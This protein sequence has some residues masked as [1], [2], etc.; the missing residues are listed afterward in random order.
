MGRSVTVQQ[1]H[2]VGLPDG[3]QYDAADGD[4]TVLLSD[5]E[6][7]NFNADVI[8]AGIVTDNGAAS[9]PGDGGGVT[10]AARLD[11]GVRW[12]RSGP[13][14]SAN[15]GIDYVADIGTADPYDEI[16]VDD[17]EPWVTLWTYPAPMVTAAG[18]YFI[19]FDV[20]GPSLA[21]TDDNLACQ[22]SM[23]FA[24]GDGSDLF[25]NDSALLDVMASD[26]VVWPSEDTPHAA[27]SV[28]IPLPANA[29]ID[30][31]G[32]F[33]GVINGAP[34]AIDGNFSMSLLIFRL[35]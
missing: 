8:T 25:R 29:H 26:R 34:Y 2:Y 35:A 9:A 15:Q 18:L 23:F 22:A 20:L 14:D 19:R 27:V 11:Q 16:V 13:F 1:P 31:G 4:I 30:V 21:I 12:D 6:W 32:Q 3:K 5:E 7:A 24:A 17:S 10:W 33:S 28:T